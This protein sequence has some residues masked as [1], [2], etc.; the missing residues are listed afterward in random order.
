MAVHGY[1]IRSIVKGTVVAV[2]AQKAMGAAS[3][4]VSTIWPASLIA[5]GTCSRVGRG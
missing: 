1:A 2:V 4:K 5:L 3:K